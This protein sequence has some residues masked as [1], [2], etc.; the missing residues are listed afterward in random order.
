MDSDHSVGAAF[1]VLPVDASIDDPVGFTEGDCGTS[2]LTFTVT[3]AEASLEPVTVTYQTQDGTALQGDDYTLTSGMLTFAPGVTSLPI[4]VPIVG[5]TAFEGDEI[6]TVEL[7]VATNATLV[8]ASGTGTILNDDPAAGLT[9]VEWVD[10]IGVSTCGPTLTK[11]QPNGWGNA[12][13]ISSYELVSGDGYV[14]FT[15]SET[16]TYKMIG[17]SNGNFDASYQDIDFAIYSIAGGQLAVYEGGTSKGSYGAFATGDTLRVAVVGG[18]VEYSKNGAVFYTSAQAPTYPLVVD[19]TLYTSGATLSKVTVSGFTPSPPPVDEPV[20]WTSAIGVTINA[21]SLTKTDPNRWGNA[22]AVSSQQ[23]VSGDG[24]VEFTASET[25]AYKMI[26]LS[27]GNFD[28]SWQDIDFAIYST[29]TGQMAVYEG[30]TSRGA[31]GAFAA[32]DT[33]RVAVVDGVVEYSRNGNV[34]YSSA[35][36][37]TY[38]LIV[39]ATL[40]TSGA[41][42]NSVVVSGFSPT[43]PPDDDPVAWTSAIGVSINGNNLTKTE[44]NG[45]GNAGAVSSQQLAAGDGYVEFTASQTDTYRMLGL[46]SGNINASYQDID[47]A[48]YVTAT[49]QMA[50]YEGGTYVGGFGAFVSGDTLRVAVVD[51]EIRYSR[52]GNVFY[53]SALAP[54]YPLI[55]DTTL[56][57]SGATFDNVLVSGFS[58]SP[59]P[60]HVP[61]TWTSAVGVTVDTNSLTKTASNGWN[62]GAVS[63]QEIASGDGYV[64]VTVGETT[65]YRMLGLSSGNTDTS[66][67]DIDFAVYL[68]ASGQIGVYEG[69]TSAGSFGA[70]LVGDILRVAVVGGEVQYARNGNVFYT[71]ALAPTYPLLVDTTLYST[72][73]TLNSVVISGAE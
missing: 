50:V 5:E 8:D 31:F 24:Y 4:D 64:E 38:P 60:D 56:Y 22:G 52:N 71:S 55:A 53:T 42:F 20:T 44:P 70:Y 14:E 3:L 16:N 7:T 25:N 15:A 62:A 72:G 54:V 29:A 18:A 51:G 6:F 48:I 40:Y 39:D 68:T 37:P 9:S 49:G 63:S 35:L 59:P 23:L 32:G 45:W 10:R 26:G 2:N 47:F 13:A 69:G 19:A 21:N 1:N 66:Y 17:L 43:P 65:T 36:I 33:L 46:S 58:A 12:G 27:N 11:T 67:Q 61:V 28:A 41:T 34:F 73:A 57:S 30:G